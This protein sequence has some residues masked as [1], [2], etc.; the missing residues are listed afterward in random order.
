MAIPV[1][2]ISKELRMKI[3]SSIL[4]G[5]A[6]VTVTLLLYCLISTDGMSN[7]IPIQQ[8]TVDSDSEGRVQTDDDRVRRAYIKLQFYHSAGNRQEALKNRRE[9]VPYDDIEIYLFNMY[10]GSI[11][12]IRNRRYFDLVTAPTDEIVQLTSYVRSSDKDP[13]EFL[14]Y[15]AKW[16]R[17]RYIPSNTMT[18][19]QFLQ[20]GGPAYSDVNKFT[21]YEVR[22]RLDGREKAYKAMVLHHS[23]AQTASNGNMEYLDLV[24]GSGGA[25]TKLS[26][27]SRPAF[28][29]G[30]RKP[31]GKGSGSPSRPKPDGQD[32]A[33]PDE[34]DPRKRGAQSG[35]RPT[36]S[37]LDRLDGETGTHLLY[38][39]QGGC[40][41][42]GICCPAGATSLTQCCQDPSYNWNSFLPTCNSGGSGGFYDRA[43][44]G[45]GRTIFDSE[46]FCHDEIYYANPIQK[47]DNNSNGHIFGTHGGSSS[48]QSFC[49]VD[50]SCNATCDANFLDDEQYEN[51]PLI[52]DTIPTL[53][54][55]FW[56]SLGTIEKRSMTATGYIGGNNTPPTCS[57]AVAFNVQTCLIGTL[58]NVGIS[59]SGSNF[60][61]NVSSNNE[62]LFTY[63]HTTTHTC[64]RL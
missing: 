58:C 50:R 19:G 47:P 43:G 48:I 20:A 13:T 28:G 36:L 1:N 39:D 64:P 18:I 45:G 5:M 12:E 10:T 9:H 11:D 30:G 53:G 17:G 40:D 6:Q 26:R 14:T 29:A 32:Q 21:S 51:G 8:E 42:S 62:A 15:E 41:Y 60:G 49:K 61:I 33:D 44:G 55:L 22:V 56:H 2:Q 52:L 3:N 23:P 7:V 27:E 37:K 34:P 38:A 59:I 57:A 24:M 31:V 54:S 16:V 63:S 25:L 35:A 46:K 4:R